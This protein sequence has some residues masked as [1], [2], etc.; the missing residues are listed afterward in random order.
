M[1]EAAL[2]IGGRE[3]WVAGA[4]RGFWNDVPPLLNRLGEIA[5]RAIGLGISFDELT[6]LNDHFVARPAEPLVPLAS[7]ETAELLGLARFGEVRVPNPAY[8]G[9]LE[10]A[11]E[12]SIPIEALEVSDEQYSQLFA[13]HISYFELVGRTLR[14]RKLTRAAPDASSAD[15]YA[16]AWEREL[17]RGR[18]SQEFLAARNAA[19]AAAAR[20][21]TERAGRVAVIVDRERFEAL[22]ALLRSA[23]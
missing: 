10:W 20:R 5:P 19:I 1:I 16:L 17:A 2:K 23:A 3:V 18:G 4:V 11:R 22:T 6:G 8:L 14:E 9:A 13:D 21:L 15:E 12:R 7:T